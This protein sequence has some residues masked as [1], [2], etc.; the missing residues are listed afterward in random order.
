MRLAVGITTILALAPPETCTKRSRI[1]RSFSLFSAPPMGTIQPR[2]SP[3]GIL[4][5]I[6]CKRLLIHLHSLPGRV[7]GSS[8]THH[9]E[10]H[11][12]GLRGPSLDFAVAHAPAGGPRP[13]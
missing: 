2:V 7:R 9:I 8:A 3:S 1:W 12:W 6:E 13:P 10:S 4:L 5:G 11:R